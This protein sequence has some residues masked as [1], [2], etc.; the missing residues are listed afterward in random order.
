MWV[1]LKIVAP[2]GYRLNA[3]LILGTVRIGGLLAA[4]EIRH[5]RT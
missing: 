5:L 4:A 2:S 3:A 1:V